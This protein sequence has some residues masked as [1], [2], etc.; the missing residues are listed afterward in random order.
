MIFVLDDDD[1]LRGLISEFLA[2]RG[3][4]CLT[5]RGRDEA[6][7]RLERELDQVC[8]LVVDRT[9]PDG[10]GLD[11]IR[12][13][14]KR[15]PDIP[16]ILICGYH[17]HPDPSEGVVF[18]PKPFRLSRLAETVERACPEAARSARQE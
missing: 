1:M 10:D 6:L 15:R 12:E 9:L 16:A 5:A 3:M 14:R 17:D 13:A 11:V 4:R 2:R 8:A 7:R 18:L